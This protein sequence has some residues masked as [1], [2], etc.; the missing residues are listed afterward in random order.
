MNSQQWYS[1]VTRRVSEKTNGRVPT[2]FVTEEWLKKEFFDG[3]SPA[4]TAR[5]ITDEI[6]FYPVIDMDVL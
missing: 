5:K 2:D 6:D 1:Q 4:T 3:N